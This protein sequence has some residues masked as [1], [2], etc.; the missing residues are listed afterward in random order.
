MAHPSRK[1]YG[2][3][4]PVKGDIVMIYGCGQS[5]FKVFL[6]PEDGGASI[7]LQSEAGRRVH[8]HKSFLRLATPEQAA[9]Y[10]ALRTAHA[11]ERR[12]QRKRW[13]AINKAVDAEVAALVAFCNES[14]LTHVENGE[15]WA[16]VRALQY[17]G[18][19][20][21]WDIVTKQVQAKAPPA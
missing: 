11:K 14:P 4:T 15:L 1:N 21:F 18:A 20:R 8:T 6:V 12:A 13:D 7:T 5:L 16:R 2:T 3:H 19:V 17:D 10:R 9:R